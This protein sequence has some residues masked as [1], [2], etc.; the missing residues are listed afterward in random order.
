MARD[1]RSA[2]SHLLTRG[3]RRA[4]ASTHHVAFMESDAGIWWSAQSGEHGAPAIPRSTAASG[5]VG[6]GRGISPLYPRR[7]GTSVQSALRPL[8]A[9]RC[10]SPA[11]ACSLEKTHVEA[12]LN[13]R[14]ATPSLQDNRIASNQHNKTGS[15][16]IP[17]LDGRLPLHDESALTC[18]CGYLQVGAPAAAG[19]AAW[20]SSALPGLLSTHVRPTGRCASGEGIEPTDQR[21]DARPPTHLGSRPSISKDPLIMRVTPLWHAGVWH[22]GVWRAGVWRAG[23]GVKREVVPA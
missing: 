21:H 19:G 6:S 10:T 3:R 12:Q 4:S 13:P 17:L 14:L 16:R 8:L 11:T 18:R 1:H 7:A 5:G 9:H 23:D 15:R 20:V 2:P 22:A